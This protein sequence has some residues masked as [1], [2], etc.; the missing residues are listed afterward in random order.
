MAT[1][2]GVEVFM[3][4]LVEEGVKYIFGNPGTTETPL[5]NILTDYPQI[6]YILALHEAV[7]VGAADAY[8]FATGEISVANLHVAPGLGNSLGMLY[9]A[10][11]G[12]SPILVTAGQQDTRMRLRDPLLAHDLVAMAA[13]LTKWSV[14]AE[15]VDEL[16]LLMHRAFKVAKEP[17]SGPVFISLPINVLE[18]STSEPVLRSTRLLPQ[19]GA[20]RAAIQEA[21]NLLLNAKKP[22]IICGDR[23]FHSRA[24]EELVKVAEFIG[25]AVWVRLLPSS[26]SFPTSHDHFRGEL[27]D[28]H[29]EIRECLGDADA[30]LIVGGDLFDEVF[31]TSENPWPEGA[32]LIQIEPSPQALAHNIF[33][34][35]GMIAN[36]KTAL[37]DLHEVMNSMA[38]A[39]FRRLSEARRAALKRIK[40]QERRQQEERI[41]DCLVCEPMTAARLMAELRDA[42]PKDA[43]VVEEA[44]TSRK[45]LMSTLNFSNPGDYYGS[46]GG[47][48][49]QGLAGALGFKLAHPN[50]PLVV[51]SG[52][53]SAMYSVQALWSAAYHNLPIVF[54]ILNNRSYR[55]LKINLDR[56]RKMFDVHGYQG[57]PFMDLKPQIDHVCLAQGYSVP[58]EK[59]TQPGMVGPALQRALESG[60]PYLLEVIID[61][62][63]PEG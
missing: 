58:A 6:N 34:E 35:V 10:F 63:Y 19:A 39:D 45:P 55:I 27:P 17:P 54:L 12:N 21:A 38:S 4:S 48:I 24:N 1:K 43:V 33:I 23:V 51:I 29:A 37:E 52:D 31:Y 7:A 3:Q 16:P 50:R 20:D 40:D 5:V 30:I 28:N 41:A 56:Y 61:G 53:G 49:G 26:V 9:N 32:R 14:Q 15:H 25:A 8:S 18:G 42:L 59:V 13:P 47:G 57:Y 62:S 36:L 44:I 2:K 22:V 11:V 60:G 46:R